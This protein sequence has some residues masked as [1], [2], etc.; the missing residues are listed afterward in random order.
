[1]QDVGAVDGSFTTFGLQE[2]EAAKDHLAIARWGRR[3]RD[4]T[5]D[6]HI[7]RLWVGRELVKYPESRQDGLAMLRSLLAPVDIVNDQRRRLRQS[8]P[9][10]QR[11]INEERA[12]ALQYIGEGLLADGQHGAALDTLRVAARTGWNVERFRDIASAALSAGDTADAAQM[13]A[14]V[15]VDPETSPA[16]VDSAQAR[17]GARGIGAGWLNMLTHSR[18]TMRERILSTASRTPL[19]GDRVRLRLATGETR[20]FAQLADGHV[21]VVA[22]GADLERKGS[23]VDLAMM[24]KLASSVAEQ[25]ARV[26]LIALHPW[27]AGMVDSLRVRNASVDVVFDDRHEAERAFDAY[28]FPIYCVVD[29]TGTIRFSYSRLTE[30]RAQVATLAQEQLVAT[31]R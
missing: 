2:A 18:V 11:E 15:A 22:F 29:A 31:R 26:L 16:F 20:T 27:R 14:L 19:R 25:N 17:L 30:L 9:E 24:Q 3:Y 7:A 4:M 8:A 21:T 10:R 13:L 5:H 12:V 23:P 6:S 1:W 28:G